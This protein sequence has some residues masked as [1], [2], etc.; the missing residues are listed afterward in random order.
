MRISRPLIALTGVVTSMMFA[1]ACGGD[2]ATNCSDYIGKSEKDQL[3]L[4]A[5]WGSPARDGKINAMA[6]MVAPDYRQK[7]IAYC[8]ESGH[9]DNKLENLTFTFR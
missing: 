7:L 3:K 9:G 5:E 6:Q 2:L 1:T 8:A 4:A